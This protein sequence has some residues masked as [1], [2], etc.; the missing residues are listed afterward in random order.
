[1][2]SSFWQFF[3]VFL[4]AAI[5]LYSVSRDGAL[6]VWESSMSQAEMQQYLD[7]VGGHGGR[8]VSEGSNRERVVSLPED[9][10]NSGVDEDETGD[11]D[12]T[13]GSEM[14]EKDDHCELC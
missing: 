14:E 11:E 9:D 13:S 1:M 7:A 5:Q 2:H 3:H 6:V 10:E 12:G 8:G 4:L